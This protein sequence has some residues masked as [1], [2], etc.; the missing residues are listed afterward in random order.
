MNTF[1]HFYSWTRTGSA[2]WDRACR[3]FNGHCGFLKSTVHFYSCPTTTHNG[4]DAFTRI[5]DIP[6]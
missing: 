6:L 3:A 2:C 4:W 1:V 5:F